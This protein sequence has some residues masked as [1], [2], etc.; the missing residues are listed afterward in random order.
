MNLN[1]LILRGGGLGDLII[2][3]PTLVS[4]KSHF[5]KSNITLISNIP[6]K[7]SIIQVLQELGLIDHYIFYNLSKSFN[8]KSKLSFYKNLSAC[9][10]KYEFSICL[11]H[12][13]RSFK[14]KFIDY[15]LFKKYISAKVG[16][17]YWN[18]T[19]LSSA[20]YPETGNLYP[21]IQEHFR[22]FHMLQSEGL[23]IRYVDP[24]KF[25]ADKKDNISSMNYNKLDKPNIILCPFGK[26]VKNHGSKSWS[27]NNYM[28][29]CKEYIAKGYKI[30]IIGAQQ[31][32]GSATQIAENL[33]EENV[34]NLCGKTSI[35]DL[36]YYLY[37]SELYL[38]D[39]TGPMHIAGVLNKKTIA[40]FSPH[41][42]PNKFAPMG[43][44]NLLFRDEISIN[45]IE[46]KH[47][48]EKIKD[49]F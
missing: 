40:F 19:D 9:K 31:D 30:V 15:L 16:I 11:R 28:E 21:M 39:D 8:I 46:A 42:N 29:V 6:E 2:T 10:R 38:G 43:M 18:S 12:S 48:I 24:F 33:N 32:Y 7:G 1:I 4:L 25:M 36:F 27:V 45:N 13:K 17:G 22:L 35:G 47:V 44:N 5:K 37:D 14:Q 41:N 20:I 23:D 26:A 34:V 49:V 3:I